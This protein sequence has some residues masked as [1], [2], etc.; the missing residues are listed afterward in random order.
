MSYGQRQ[1]KTNSI[2]KSENAQKHE[3][4]HPPLW[5]QY[6]TQLKKYKQ[7][8]W[9]GLPSNDR[10]GISISWSCVKHR[11][12]SLEGDDKSVKQKL[13]NKEIRPKF[14]LIY[15]ILWRGSQLNLNLIPSESRGQN[16]TE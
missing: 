5:S 6:A 13:Q 2:Q 12:A 10:R 15:S 16:S 14:V 4:E 1:V 7:L 9:V 3:K 8:N 11:V